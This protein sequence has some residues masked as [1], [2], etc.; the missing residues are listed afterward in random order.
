MKTSVTRNREVYLT[1]A[2]SLGFVALL[3]FGRLW[4]WLLEEQ[5]LRENE[6][7]LISGILT[8]LP[9]LVMAL[10]FLK[11]S[12]FQRF[13]GIGYWGNIQQVQA[14][15]IPAVIISMGFLG[16]L[17]VYMDAGAWLL[18]LFIVNTLLVALIEELTFRG[19]ILPLIMKGRRRKKSVLFVSVCLASGIFGLLH[20]VNLFKEPDN[21]WGITSQVLFAFS[22]GVFLGGLLLRTRHILFPVFIHFFVNFSFG[23]GK[24]KEQVEEVV[25]TES[26]ANELDLGSLITLAFFAFMIV[27]AWYM[28]RKVDRAYVLDTLGITDNKL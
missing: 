17:Q 22:I 6:R 3:A 18:S 8:R 13:A 2:I 27:G 11:K 26:A 28:I 10:Y 19:L 20:Y 1:L 24:L 14:V 23:N 12:G 16:S 15:L 9:I 4:G 25:D 21:F 7:D 5:I